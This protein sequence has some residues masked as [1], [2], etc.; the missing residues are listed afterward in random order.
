MRLKLK[1]TE[2]P[3]TVVALADFV[4]IRWRIGRRLGSRCYS[5]LRASEETR[6]AVRRVAKSG[7]AA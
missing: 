4:T 7:P 6:G 2:V 1:K 3:N 5:V